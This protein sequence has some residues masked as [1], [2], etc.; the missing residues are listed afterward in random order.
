M[1]G[2]IRRLLLVGLMCLLPSLAVG[3][4]LTDAQI[5][6][7]FGVIAF[8]NEF[9]VIKDPRIIKWTTPI[10][11]HLRQDVA[12]EPAQLDFLVKHLK[13]LAAITGISIDY[14]DSE[15][16]T[17][18]LIIFTREKF[19]SRL[20]AKYTDIRD[21]SRRAA[22]G[23]ELARNNCL[24]FYSTNRKDFTI[25]RATILI[26]VDR[27]MGRGILGL[28]MIEETTQAMGLPNDS[29]DVNPS[30]F[31]DSSQLKR[32]TW[33]DV[34]LL[35]LLYHPRMKP[36]MKPAEA[37]AIARQILPPMRK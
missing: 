4:E 6:R 13:H 26:P 11:V 34:L 35:R 33:Q 12:L 3:V 24:A 8:G 16:E 30:I 36:G 2:P 5:V 15:R 9:R 17:N 25:S 1:A 27:A 32:L 37:L 31:N 28:C 14:V 20:A 10:R 18:F 21:K 7:N 22:M 29:D 19:F 23:R